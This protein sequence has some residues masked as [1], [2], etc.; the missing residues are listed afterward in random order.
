MRL[1][2]IAQNPIAASLAEGNPKSTAALL[3][4]AAAV[5]SGVFLPAALAHSTNESADI[6]MRAARVL[7]AI[8]AGAA[9]DRLVEMLSD[10]A[11][12]VRAVAATAIGTLGH[13]PAAAA[14]ARLVGDAEW[15]VRMAASVALQRLGAPGELLLRRARDRNDGPGAEVARQILDVAER[16]RPAQPS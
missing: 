6:R 8:G 1:G 9:L 2:T 3:D 11:A 4:V 10:T 5:S 13:W 15:D 14:L 12:A 16:L 7:A